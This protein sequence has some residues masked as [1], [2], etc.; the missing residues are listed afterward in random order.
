MTDEFKVYQEQ[1]IRN[2][3]RF[4]SAL[5]AKGYRIVS[6]GTDTHLFLVDLT[7]I[8]LTGKEAQEILEESGI[9]LN[10]N[11]IPFDQKGPNVTSGVRIGTPAI[12][13]RGMKEG[14]MEVIADLIDVVL[15]NRD[16]KAVQARVKDEVRALCKDFPFY[17]RIYQI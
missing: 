12:T 3:R 4:S 13:T 15:R 16:D 6:G 10:R 1:I 7:P 8:G 11:L 5:E 14:E 2:A 17:S 9:M